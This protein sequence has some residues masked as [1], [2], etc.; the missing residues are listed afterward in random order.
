MT[1]LSPLEVTELFRRAPDRHLDVGE[2]EVA[3]RRVGDGP[4]VLFV[5]GWPVSGAT[6]RKLLPH[7]APHVTCHVIDLPG[8]GS[9]K[10]DPATS[11]GSARRCG[12]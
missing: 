2:G 11:R 1:G 7:L 6:W 5:H 8:A 3:Y 10:F 9:S 4:D 12:C